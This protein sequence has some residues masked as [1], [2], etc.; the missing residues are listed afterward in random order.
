[1]F[2][3]GSEVFFASNTSH[4]KIV[5]Q[6]TEGASVLEF[7]CATGYM[8]RYLKENKHCRVYGIEIDEE[9]I[10]TASHYLDRAICCNVEHVSWAEEIAGEKFDYILFADV[11]EHLRNPDEVLR[12]AADF[13]KDD[14]RIIVSVPNITHSDIILKMLL[15][16]F[17]YTKTGLLDNTHIHF[18]GSSNLKDFFDSFGLTMTVLDGTVM[19]MGTT[20]QKCTDI[21]S[22]L[23]KIIGSKAYGNIY[24]F[25]CV[26]YKKEYA[27]KQKIEFKT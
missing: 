17:E 12:K 2:K 4:G 25:I 10:K 24:Q 3:Y 16:H 20:E 18:W 26:L 7:G 9:A 13:L 23:A 6:I 15:N 19:P 14:G 11:L 5:E 22:D 1:M 21:N 8:S 27:E